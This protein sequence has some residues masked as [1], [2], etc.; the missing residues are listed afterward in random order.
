M[1]EKRATDA[2]NLAALILSARCALLRAVWLIFSA[3]VICM[4][5]G[6]TSVGALAASLKYRISDLRHCHGG[7]ELRLPTLPHIGGRVDA[8]GLVRAPWGPS[9][10][11]IRIRTVRINI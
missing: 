6:L 9:M 2:G 7:H 10:H 11:R 5:A 3:A 8:R 1:K 4:D